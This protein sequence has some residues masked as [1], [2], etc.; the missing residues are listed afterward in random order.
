[1]NPSCLQHCLTASESDHFEEFGYVMIE[2]AVSTEQLELLS[3]FC[4][5]MLEDKRRQGLG[6]Y[7]SFDEV[8]LIGKEPVFL[9]MIDWETTFPKVWGVLGWNIYLYHTGLIVNPPSDPNPRSGTPSVA[10]HQD[11]MRVNDEMESSPR[12]RLSLKVVYLI[13]DVSE[14]GR[15]NTWIVPGSH[16]QNEIEIPADGQSHP[17]GAIPICGVPGTAFLLDRRLWHSRSRNR[18]ELT[19]KVLLMGYGYRWLRPKDEMTVEHLYSDLDPIR[20]QIL[21]DV[22]SNNSRYAPGEDDVPLRTWLRQHRPTDAAWTQRRSR[23]SY[24]PDL[25]SNRERKDR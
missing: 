16:L 15:A 2:N 14:P 25:A 24:R 4:D 20:R 3:R 1:M 9:E 19:R 12:P 8:D 23:Q 5:R 18:S 10:W 17:S 7:E 21:G 13:S 22:P 6:T 11:S